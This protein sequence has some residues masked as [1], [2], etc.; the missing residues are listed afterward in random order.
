MTKSEIEGR[1]VN[2]NSDI[3]IKKKLYARALA[4]LWLAFWWWWHF[5]HWPESALAG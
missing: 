3:T 4:E 2:T 1:G 5:K